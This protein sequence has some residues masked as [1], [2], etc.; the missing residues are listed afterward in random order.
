MTAPAGFAAASCRRYTHRVRYRRYI[1]AF[2]VLSAASAGLI[3]SNYRHTREEAIRQLYAQERILAQQAAS[4]IEEYFAYYESSLSFLAADR[5]VAFDTPEGRR[6]LRGFYLAQGQDLASISRVDERGR[7]EYTYPHES[8]SGTSLAEQS[9]V[10]AFLAARKP[11]L[12]GV[13]HSV[14]GFDAVALYMPI[15][16][17]GSFRGGLAILVP[18]DRISRRFLERISVN[19]SGY[20]ILLDAEGTELYSPASGNQGHSIYDNAMAMTSG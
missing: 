3:V 14:Q 10:R 15:F 13:F 12:S 20:A 7:L 9:H 4:S 8:S 5:G 16:E 19:G 2:L 6:M 1:A 11:L 17:D 18:F